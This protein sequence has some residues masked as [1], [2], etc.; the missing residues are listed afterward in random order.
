MPEDLKEFTLD[1]IKEYNGQDGKPTYVVYEGRVYDLTESKKWKNGRHMNRHESGGDLTADIQAAPHKPDVLERFPQ[2][3]VLKKQEEADDGLYVPEFVKVALDA[4]PMLQR[5]PH[6]M[7]VHFPI[8]FMI[9]TA[10]FTFLY[11]TSGVK[12]FETTAFHLLGAGVLFNFVA[13]TTGLMTWYLNYMAR[14]MKE[15][16]IKLSLSALMVVISIVLFIWRLLDPTVLEQLQGINILYLL[17]ALSLFPHCQHHR[18][19]R[20]ELTF[21][22]HG[23]RE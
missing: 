3:G 7:T 12:S 20:A 2:I 14:P 8:V 10:L 13:I 1:E 18:I 15:V 5:H 21:P 4:F 11:V 6:P 22:T 19:F 16:I 9:S 23:G 17:L